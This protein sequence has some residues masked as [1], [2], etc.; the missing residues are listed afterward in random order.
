V[1]VGAVAL[2]FSM[3]DPRITSTIVGVTKPERVAETLEWAGTDIPNELWQEL[4]A[5]PTSTE[6]PEANR[7]YRL[8]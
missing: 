1:P 6:D 7:D 4:E 5:I 3:R 2:Q 8:G